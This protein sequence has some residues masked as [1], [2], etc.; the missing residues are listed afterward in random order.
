MSF[1]KIFSI[2]L[3]TESVW[4]KEALRAG[5]VPNNMKQVSSGQ[6]FPKKWGQF[7][8]KDIDNKYSGKHQ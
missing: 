5:D 7:S 4:N 3:L 6:H 2:R 8:K 1:D